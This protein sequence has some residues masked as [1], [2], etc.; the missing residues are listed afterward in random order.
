[1]FR[2]V[3]LLI[4]WLVVSGLAKGV[5]PT[6]EKSDLPRIPPTSPKNVIN[7]FSIREGFDIQLVASEPLV[8]DPVAMAFDEYGRLYVVEMIGYSEHRDDRLGRVRL[9]EDENGDGRFDRS[10]VF[11]ADLAWPTAVACF[12]GGVFVGATP[13]ILYLKDTDGDRKADER[14]VALTGFGQA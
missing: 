9:L 10:T 14:N 2:L 11:A 6:A 5:E 1:M 12:D 13:D 4:A 3:P 8:V 7:T